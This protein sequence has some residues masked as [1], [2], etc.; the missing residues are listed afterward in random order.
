MN[1]CE[2]I[3]EARDEGAS[4]VRILSVSVASPLEAAR[5]LGLWDSAANF[6]LTQS[7]AA[8]VLCAL[9]VEDMAYNSPIVPVREAEELTKEFI[10]AI[11]GEDSMFF[12]NA[13]WAKPSRVRHTASLELKGWIPATP[14]TFDSGILVL[15]GSRIGCAWFMDED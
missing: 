15:A 7:D 13:R 10:E 3:S 2:R 4:I 14:H 9:L 8:A 1:I 11:G 6:E 12:T 5:A